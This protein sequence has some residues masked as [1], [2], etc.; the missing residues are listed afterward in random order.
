M[1]NTFDCLIGPAPRAE[2]P[3]SPNLPA[4]RRKCKRFIE[5][6]RAQFGREPRGARFVIVATD[7][8]FVSRSPVSL[9]VAL[10]IEGGAGATYLDQLKGAWETWH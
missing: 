9:Q 3:Y 10:R 8:C 1:A 4:A 5:Q 2:T 6:L 7:D